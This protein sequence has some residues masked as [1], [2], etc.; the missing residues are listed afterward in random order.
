MN[1]LQYVLSLRPA[2]PLSIERASK[3]KPH[4][5]PSNGEVRRWINNGSV[6]INE[7]RWTHDEE[8]PPMVWSLVFFPSSG[9]RRATLI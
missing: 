4:S 1:V 2:L 6:Q 7:E 3:N 8:A 5:A 9:A